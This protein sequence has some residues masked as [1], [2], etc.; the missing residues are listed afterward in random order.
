LQFDV[1]ET[2]PRLLTVT[3]PSWRATKDVSLREDLV[4]EI[5][6]MIGYGEM[7][8]TAPFVASVVPPANPTRE[9]H[10]RLRDLVS[11]QGFTEAYNYSFLSDESVAEFGF[12]A[13][14]HLRV[15]NPIAS[16]Q[17][18]MRMSLIPGIVGNLRE[19]RKHSDAFRLFEIGAEIHKQA[20]GPPAETP[21]LAAAS[22]AKEGDGSAG[23][24]ELKRL[25]ECIVAGAA[26]KPCAAR[27]FEHPARSVVLLADGRE[28]GRLFEVHPNY[29]EGGRGAIL[30]LDLKAV[31]AILNGRSV[32]YRAP[33]RFPVSAFDLSVI[34]G[35][36]TL[37]GDIDAALREYA[38]PGLV[39]MEF[40][41][42]YSGP[43]LAEG[44][45]SVSFR[46][47]IG[48]P[49]RTLSSQEVTVVRDRIIEGMRS[50]G[51]ELRV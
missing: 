15:L 47:T 20:E 16:D 14:D 25:A 37:T 42:Q 46:L 8:P 49:D 28:F 30:D 17:A 35:I 33:R 39:A 48:A 26:V 44:Q 27:A 21:H 23:L 18:L 43:P 36:R 5:G 11:A 41:R 32:K 13:S 10:H 6:R 12:Q 34:T 24:F 7:T 19:N 45:K 22:F 1:E 29:L 51:F 38:G 9:F 50:R 40:Q 3:V 31:E 4:E 2:G